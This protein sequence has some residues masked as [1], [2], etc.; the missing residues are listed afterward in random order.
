MKIKKR[1]G[2]IFQDAVNLL[3]NLNFILKP[4]E[5]MLAENNVEAVAGQRPRI[6]NVKVIKLGILK[7]LLFLKVSHQGPHVLQIAVG[8]PLVDPE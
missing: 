7:A 6:A 4:E 3:K 8:L 1:N 5:G 2:V